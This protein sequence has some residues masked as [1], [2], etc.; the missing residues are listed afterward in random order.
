MKSTI[1]TL[2]ILAGISANVFAQD[3]KGGT[4][5]KVDF[6]KSAG[7]VEK[8][9]HNADSLSLEIE[10]YFS[11]DKFF[12]SGWSFGYRKED[13]RFL[14]AGQYFSVKAFHDFNIRFSEMQLGVGEEWGYPSLT[15]EKTISG[16]DPSH[17]ES[18]RHIFPIRNSGIP[19]LGPKKDGT[20]YPFLSLTLSKRVG[21]FRLEGGVR[22][23]FRK[24]GLDTYGP[25]GQFSSSEK[26]TASP[27]A[28]IGFGL[29]M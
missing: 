24:F 28:L 12:L 1:F 10:S 13:I 18:F 7:A 4:F 20:L 11:K 9:S 17:P 15:S 2:L 23:D 5:F 14:D 19:F 6:M 27:S 8:V 26:W 21:I 29:R 22:M 3:K 16:I 25:D